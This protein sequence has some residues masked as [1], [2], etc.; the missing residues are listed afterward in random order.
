[1]K[2][3]PI[4]RNDSSKGCIGM[5]SAHVDGREIFFRINSVEDGGPVIKVGQTVTY[6]LE[7]KDGQYFAVNIEVVDDPEQWH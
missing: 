1:M 3:Q 7:E 2:K 4:E 6:D 5:I